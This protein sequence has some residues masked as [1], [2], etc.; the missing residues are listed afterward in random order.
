MKLYSS[1]NSELLVVDRF[2]RN[3]NN[4][5]IEG[6]IMGALPIRANLKPAEIRCALGMMDFK[7]KLF[8]LSMLFRPSR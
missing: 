4:L 3:K 7:T 6:T 1:D 2:S 8:A 5:V